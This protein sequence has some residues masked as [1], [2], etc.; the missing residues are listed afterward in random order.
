MRF[1]LL[2]AA[3]LAASPVVASVCKPRSN[4]GSTTLSLDYTT[5]IL[6][7]ITSTELESIPMPIATTTSA[8]LSTTIATSKSDDET[9]ESAATA[10]ICDKVERL[11][12]ASAPTQR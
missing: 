10:A 3:A 2:C 6:T 1:P 12:E 4:S 7:S 8:D 5:S 9:T 11:K